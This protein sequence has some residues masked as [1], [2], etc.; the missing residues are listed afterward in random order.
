MECSVNHH[1]VLYHEPTRLYSRG[2]YFYPFRC[3]VKPT[4]IWIFLF[5]IGRLPWVEFQFHHSPILPISATRCPMSCGETAIEIVSNIHIYN[6][7]ESNENPIEIHG[8]RSMS[9]GHRS[10]GHLSLLSMFWPFT[11][12]FESS[13]KCEKSKT[14]GCL[15]SYVIW[16]TCT[17]IFALLREFYS[18]S[19]SASDERMRERE[20]GDRSRSQ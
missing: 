8:I 20:S 4:K 12:S 18:T 15:K 17:N 3:Y 16:T 9:I 13:L 10:C 19:D 2:V 1:V 14:L 6:L 5:H 7:F 11:H